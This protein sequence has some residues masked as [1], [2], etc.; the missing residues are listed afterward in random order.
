MKRAAIYV[1]SITAVAAVLAFIAT[2]VTAQWELEHRTT[3]IVKMA[4]LP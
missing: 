1:A 3:Q 2:M 4:T